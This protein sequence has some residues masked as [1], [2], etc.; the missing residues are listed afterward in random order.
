MDELRLFFL[1]QITNR[2]IGFLLDNVLNSFLADDRSILVCDLF[3]LHFLILGN[4]V[5]EVGRLLK[6]FF[7]CS[8]RL[9]IFSLNQALINYFR[10]HKI[11]G[12]VHLRT[13]FI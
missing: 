7:S 2:D 8:L 10:I 5:A 4:L 3:L 1:F 6:I 11:Q 12:Q 9:E 13:S